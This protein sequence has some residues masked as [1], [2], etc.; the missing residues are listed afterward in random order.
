MGTRLDI[1][2][3]REY[4]IDLYKRFLSG[5]DIQGEARKTFTDYRGSSKFISLDMQKSI[6][7]LED[8][9]WGI[10][11]Q[12]SHITESPR[13]RALKILKSLRKEELNPSKEWFRDVYEKKK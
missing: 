9:G 11:P 12:V 7:Y 3:L 1:P 10:P 6:G 4:L 13:V 5:E 2:E 8:I